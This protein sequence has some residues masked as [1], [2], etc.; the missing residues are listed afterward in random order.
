MFTSS[1]R[2]QVIGGLLA[3]RSFRSAWPDDSRCDH[4]EHLGIPPF[5]GARG[6][7][8]GSRRYCS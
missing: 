7:A 1:E 8:P 3:D 4:S 6:T 2:F 5:D